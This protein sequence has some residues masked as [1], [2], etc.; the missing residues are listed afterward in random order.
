M[1]SDNKDTLLTGITY[2]NTET[3]YK[4]Y[5]VQHYMHINIIS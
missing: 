3:L 4:G 1:I 2:A 5:A